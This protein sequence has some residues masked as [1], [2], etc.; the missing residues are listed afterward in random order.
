MPH[1]AGD[2]EEWQDEVEQVDGYLLD[3]SEGGAAL[4]ANELKMAAGDPLEFWSA[5]AEVWLA[6]T[7]AR[8]LREEQTKDGTIFHLQFL[9]PPNEELR[10]AIRALQMGKA[11]NRSGVGV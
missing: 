10:A 2:E 4:C 3:L 1:L 5:D 11:Q 8:V 6:P 9:D 7:A